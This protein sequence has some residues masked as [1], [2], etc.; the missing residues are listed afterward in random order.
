MLIRWHPIDCDS[1]W[2]KVWKLKVLPKVLNLLWGAL[3]HCLITLSQLHIKH[4]PMQK[5]CPMCNL[6]DETEFHVLVSCPFAAQCCQ[7]R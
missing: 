3:S 1:L 2:N 6:A 4:V 7:R 5:T